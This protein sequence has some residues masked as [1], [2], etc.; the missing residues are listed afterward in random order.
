MFLAHDTVPHVSPIFSLVYSNLPSVSVALSITLATLSFSEL[1]SGVIFKLGSK[2]P[3]PRETTHCINSSGH[4]SLHSC[5]AI[6]VGLFVSKPPS[7]N[8]HNKKK[9][10]IFGTNYTNKTIFCGRYVY[11]QGLGQKPPLPPPPSLL[12]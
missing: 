8:L 12:F 3:F 2:R 5:T 1:L 6:A 9:I 10:K 4:N 7:W 11:I